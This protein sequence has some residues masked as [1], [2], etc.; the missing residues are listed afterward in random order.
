M[1][2][3]ANRTCRPTNQNLQKSAILPVHNRIMIYKKF[4]KYIYKYFFKKENIGETIIMA[5][6]ETIMSAFYE[7]SQISEIEFKNEI[8]PTLLN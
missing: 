8:R 4:N 6:D 1:H 7:K 5:V 2:T 3:F